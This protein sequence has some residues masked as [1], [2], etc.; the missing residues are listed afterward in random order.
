MMRIA[1]VLLFLAACETVDASRAQRYADE[2]TAK[3]FSASSTVECAR[4]DSDGD[5]YVSCTVFEKDH[6][7]VSIQCGAEKWCA[8]NCAEG[9]KYV[10]GVKVNAR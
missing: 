10:P 9:C 3:H 8:R 7:P 4:A 1:I 2:Y 5:G 6:D